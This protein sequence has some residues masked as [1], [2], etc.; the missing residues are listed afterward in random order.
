MFRE[1]I[2]ASAAMLAVAV[3]SSAPQAGA[4]GGDQVIG[5]QGG[6][7]RCLL[8]AD[9]HGRGYPMAVCGR[10]DGQGFGQ[11]PMS[12]GK[13]PVRLNLAVLKGTGEIWWEAGPAPGAPSGDVAVNTGQRYA[14][15]GW[16]VEDQGLKTMITNDK[17]RHGIFVNLVDVRQF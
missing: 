11:S 2:A 5:V 17:T 10:A 13:F 6:Q 9:Y 8:S 14:A 3:C 1:L 15:N 16:T 7:V 12:T 4:A